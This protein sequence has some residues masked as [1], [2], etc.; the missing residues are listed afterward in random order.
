MDSQTVIRIL[1][2]SAVGSLAFA[3]ATYWGESHPHEYI[4]YA[5]KKPVKP[6]VLQDSAVVFAELFAVFSIAGLAVFAFYPKKF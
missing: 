4:T 5:T 2:S 6:H 1:I 3:G